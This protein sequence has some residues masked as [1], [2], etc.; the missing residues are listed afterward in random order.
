MPARLLHYCH[1]G[2]RIAHTATEILH[3]EMS[4]IV[5]GYRVV[6]VTEIGNSRHGVEGGACEPSTGRGSH[7]PLNS[8]ISDGLRIL[9]IL[10]HIYPCVSCNMNKRADGTLYTSSWRFSGLGPTLL[11]RAASSAAIPT[12]SR[13]QWTALRVATSNSSSNANF[14]REPSRDT[15]SGA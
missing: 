11:S 2:G 12:K 6:V 3:D 15:N 1:D 9:R 5:P 10:E 13:R 14:R 8:S 4:L 7:L